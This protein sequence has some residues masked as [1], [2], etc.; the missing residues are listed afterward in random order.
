MEISKIGFKGV[1]NVPMQATV[2]E[3]KQTEQF[4]DKEKS[5]AAKYM[6][7]ATALAGVIG[8][9]IAGRKG[10]LGEGIQKFLGG[11]KKSASETASTAAAAGSRTAPKVEKFTAEELEKISK[12]N[13]KDLTPEE[14]GKIIDTVISDDVPLLKELLKKHRANLAQVKDDVPVK[15]VLDKIPVLQR[16]LRIKGIEPSFKKVFGADSPLTK[17]LNEL[18]IGEVLD[19]I[20]EKMPIPEQYKGLISMLDRNKTVAETCEPFLPQIKQQGIELDFS[21]SLLDH[22]DVWQKFSL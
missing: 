13:I 14:Y 4:E 16:Y 20:P 5:N 12:K 6:I 8:L 15:E 17:K 21:K 9:G 3:Q 22:A 10:H 11:A 1:E 18:K 7:G 2:V 19:C